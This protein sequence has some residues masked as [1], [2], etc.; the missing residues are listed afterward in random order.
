MASI[1][2]LAFSPNPPPQADTGW[3][4]LNHALAFAALAVCGWFAWGDGQRR[5]VAVAVA[6]WAFAFG[7]FIELV[8]T[9]IPGR[10]G[11]WPDLVADAVGIA[12]G[13]AIAALAV[14]TLSGRLTP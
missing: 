10:S 12:A 6:V 2:W 8:Q 5:V 1:C 9:Q 3:D 13:L 11:E 4:K 14:K 7:V